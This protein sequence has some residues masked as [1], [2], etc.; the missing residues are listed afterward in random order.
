MSDP[1]DRSDPPEEYVV[2]PPSTSCHGHRPQ[3]LWL[4]SGFAVS[5]TRGHAVERCWAHR[6]RI[7]QE[8]HTVGFAEGYQ[9]GYQEG[10]R[11]SPQG[12][13]EAYDEHIDTLRTVAREHG[14]ALAVHGSLKRDIDL[15][16]APWVDEAS[17]AETLA[18]ALRNAVHGAFGQESE[19]DARPHGRHTWAIKLPEFGGAY[20]DLSVMPTRERFYSEG[21]RDGLARGPRPP[22][23]AEQ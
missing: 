22:G 12:I 2:L 7:Y 20:F 4:G 17:D 1:T 5:A 3:A 9:A 19:A 23:G 13:R 21:M 18:A 14:Y 10:F 16:A 11:K 8:G 15:I 6:D